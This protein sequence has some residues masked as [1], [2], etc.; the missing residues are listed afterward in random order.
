[1]D[2]WKDKEMYLP[3]DLADTGVGCSAS[4]SLS[5]SGLDSSED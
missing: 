5:H 1:M 3:L 4:T 2:D